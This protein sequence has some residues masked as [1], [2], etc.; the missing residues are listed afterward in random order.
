MKWSLLLV[1]I[2]VVDVFAA[3]INACVGLTLPEF[4][5]VM[6][7]R[8]VTPIEGV[9]RYKMPSTPP[10]GNMLLM[11]SAPVD[12]V[13]VCNW[14]ALS[15]SLQITVKLV[16]DVNGNYPLPIGVRNDTKVYRNGV[17]QLLGEDYTIV[18]NVVIPRIDY[19]WDISDLIIADG[20]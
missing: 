11:C 17:R 9:V 13:S 1:F 10:T 8:G 19:P 15:S 5:T 2:F 18:A 4:W 16:R 7:M 20:N 3:D 6:N 14:L 12:N